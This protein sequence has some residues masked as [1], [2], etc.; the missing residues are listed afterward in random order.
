MSANSTLLIDGAAPVTTVTVEPLNENSEDYL[1]KWSA[2]EEENG[3][4]VKHF[5]V[6][7]AEDGGDFAIWRS[8]TTDTEAVYQDEAGHTY[9]FLALATDNAGNREVANLG[10]LPDDGSG[11]NLGSLPNL[12]RTSEPTPIPAN[13][14]SPNYQTNPLFTEAKAD[15]PNTTSVTNPSEFTSVLRPYWVDNLPPGASFD[16]STKIF[17]WLPSFESAGT[18]EVTFTATDGNQETSIATNL[19]ISQGNQ[20]PTLLPISDKPNGMASLRTFLEGD[21]IRVQLQAND[22]END[23]LTFSSNLLPGGSFLDPNTG[24][25]AWT[26]GFFQAGNY[27]IPFTV[28]DGSAS[29]TQTFNLEILNVNAAPQ[30]D[31]LGDWAVA[32]GQTINFRAF[33]RDGDNPSF[34]PQERNGEGELTLLEGSEPTVT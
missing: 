12:G 23:K 10:N 24:V 15:V 4:G 13:P 11:I 17:S 27:Q 8:Q 2:T 32:E 22:T 25:F 21:A 29:T 34:I 6:Y 33:A 16:P 31:N 5:T 28:S 19:L 14:P 18:Y 9:E 26:P 7:V 20:A 30:F 3:S 1:V